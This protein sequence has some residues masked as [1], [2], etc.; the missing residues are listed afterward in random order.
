MT[1]KGNK[2]G[3]IKEITIFLLIIIIGLMYFYTPNLSDKESEPGNSLLSK[4]IADR[5]IVSVLGINE[6]GGIVV[7]GPVD[8]KIV[9]TCEERAK[10]DNPCRAKVIKENG[11]YTLVSNNANQINRK[12]K[13]ELTHRGDITLLSQNQVV[14][15]YFKGSYCTTSYVGGNEFEKCRYSDGADFQIHRSNNEG[16]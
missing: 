3:K 10:S 12:Q 5:G 8:G 1:N 16:P 9:K 4:N 7:F 6:K 11:E 15:F 14:L 2:M 13:D